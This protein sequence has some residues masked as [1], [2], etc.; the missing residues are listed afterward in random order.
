MSSGVACFVEASLSNALRSALKGL[1]VSLA[2][3][4]REHLLREIVQTVELFQRVKL[5]NGLFEIL[6][7]SHFEYAVPRPVQVLCNR[8]ASSN[9]TETAIWGTPMFYLG[10]APQRSR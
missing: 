10:V 1:A 3:S 4:S 5:R 8:G 6:A 9:G 7:K 2:I